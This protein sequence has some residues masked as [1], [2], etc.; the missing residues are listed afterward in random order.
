MSRGT[1]MATHLFSETKAMTKISRAAIALI[2]IAVWF[3]TQSLLA[4]RGF[5][6]DIGDGLHLFLSPLTEWLAH[7]DS[8]ANILLIA[9]S[10]A[11]DFLGCYLLFAG[12]MGSTVRPLLGLFLLFA[13]RQL[14]QGLIALPAPPNM[15][16]RDPGVPSLLVTYQTGNDF[17]FSGH[18]AIAAYGALELWRYQRPCLKFA[19]VLI[20]TI[21]A[22]TVLALRAHYT[23]DVFTA[24]L[25][26]WWA[27]SAAVKLAP[28]CDGWLVSLS[29]TWSTA[30]DWRK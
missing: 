22:L 25:A 24:I 18:T 12:V 16:W 10:A 4:S 2:G 7:H 28:V 29:S 1:E 19:S 3:V 6:N 30:L 17:F 20:A 9:T 14:C 15:I 8:A 23:M 26:A 27:S 21:E 13:L 11:I 5:P